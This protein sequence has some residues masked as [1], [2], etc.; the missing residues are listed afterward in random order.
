MAIVPPP[1]QA[2]LLGLIDGADHQADA[3]GEQLDLGN[4]DLDIAGDDQP[5]VEYSIENVDEAR[6]ASVADLHGISR[7]SGA[8]VKV[9]SIHLRLTPDEK[10]GATCTGHPNAAAALG[11]PA[12]HA[13]LDVSASAEWLYA[14]G[15]GGLKAGGTGA[16]GGGPNGAAAFGCPGAG[17][18][19]ACARGA[20]S[21][22]SSRLY[23][24]S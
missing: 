20:R 2:N 23:F 3:D 16:T 17:A 22:V 13:G 21:C 11:A 18:A 10:A 7:H 6:S 5:L 4:R 14:S 12:R 8:S 24:F 15:T 9:S 19:A 1:V